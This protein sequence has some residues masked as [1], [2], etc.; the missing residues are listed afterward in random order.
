MRVGEFRNL[1]SDL[2]FGRPVRSSRKGAR[3]IAV[4]GT[5]AKFRVIVTSPYPVLH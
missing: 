5:E 4:D 1:M 3:A 2:H